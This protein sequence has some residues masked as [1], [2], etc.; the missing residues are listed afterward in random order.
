MLR[1][2]KLEVI[3]LRPLDLSVGEGLCEILSKEYDGIITGIPSL[4]AKPDA[5]KRKTGNQ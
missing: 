2:G 5:T 1:A 4:R 3:H